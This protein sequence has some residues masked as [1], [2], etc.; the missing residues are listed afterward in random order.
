MPVLYDDN[1]G[2]WH[3]DDAEELTFFKYVQS[4]SVTT[5]CERCQG[6]VR[7][8]PPKLLCAPCVSALECGAPLSMGEY[9]PSRRRR[10]GARARPSAAS[11]EP[12]PVRAIETRPPPRVKLR[13]STVARLRRA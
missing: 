3:V 6:A 8:A 4:Q 2:Y 10:A 9:E 11:S 1:F 5:S 13:R 7:L 12:I